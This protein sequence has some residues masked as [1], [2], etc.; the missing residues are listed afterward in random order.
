MQ[1]ALPGTPAVFFRY[2]ISSR[3]RRGEGGILVALSLGLQGTPA[4]WNV[5]LLPA[6][7]TL[8]LDCSFPSPFPASPLWRPQAQP[9]PGADIGAKECCLYPHTWLVGV[10]QVPFCHLWG[11]GVTSSL[12]GLVLHLQGEAPTSS[13]QNR[14]QRNFRQV[15]NPHQLWPPP[16]PAVPFP[17]QPGGGGVREASSLCVLRVSLF[18]REAGRHESHSTPLASCP[19]SRSV[20]A[21]LRPCAA[22]SPRRSPRP[23]ALGILPE[24]G[25]LEEEEEKRDGAGG[26]C[27]TA[28]G[29]GPR[30]RRL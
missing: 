20:L 9:S 28:R 12:P 14:P 27:R 16:L 18:F 8:I 7:E 11:R 19:A 6:A 25:G 10:Y 2:R 13:L 3:F 24:K 5:P 29:R 21:S 22:S 15:P 30:R 26:E 1:P 4:P 17:Q 23:P